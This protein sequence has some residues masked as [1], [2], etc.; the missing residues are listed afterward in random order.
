M[1]LDIYVG[2]LTRYYSGQWE[3]I[4]ARTMR[5]Q[6]TPFQVIRPNNPSDAVTDPAQIT[7]AV[8][9]WRRGLSEALGSYLMR[10][11]D[12]S[13]DVASPYFTDK[14]D[15]D[16]LAGVLLWAAYSEQPNLKR[17]IGYTKEFGNDPAFKAGTAPGSGSKL[18]PV[19]TS[20]LWLP[21]DSSIVF[22]AQDVAGKQIG[23]SFLPAL[24]SALDDVNQRTWQ[25][26]RAD[27]AAWRR[28]G[29]PVAAGTLDHQAQFGYAILYELTQS[30]LDSS[31]PMKLDY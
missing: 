8:I 17:P 11:L 3:T 15:W 18:M 22:Q 2:N 4:V 28:R 7:P 21:G 27:I 25:A 20:E 29:P 5:E 23:M 30:A 1:G 9:A 19:L 6:G 24:Q 14:P 10:P 13:E 26:T 31:L 12:W 16:G